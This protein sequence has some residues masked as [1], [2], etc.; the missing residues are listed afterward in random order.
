MGSVGL[1]S[2]FTGEGSMDLSGTSNPTGIDGLLERLNNE[3]FDLVA[4]G[5]ALLV[6][7]NW[8][9]KI[10]EQKEDEIAPFNKEAL[11]SLS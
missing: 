11:T 2:D 9:N 1:D 7:P 10:K 6:D 5:R 8:V 4:I 3:E